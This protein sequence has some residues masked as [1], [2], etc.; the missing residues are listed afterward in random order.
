MRFIILSEPRGDRGEVEGC[1]RAR[2]KN[3]FPPHSGCV[4]LSLP[5]FHVVSS[6]DEGEKGALCLQ[7]VALCVGEALRG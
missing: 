1:H 2:V 3:Y 7:S 6:R 4:F 5:L